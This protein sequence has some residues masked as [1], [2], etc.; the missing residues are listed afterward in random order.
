M[1]TVRPTRENIVIRHATKVAIG[2]VTFLMLLAAVIFWRQSVASEEAKGWVSHTYEVIGHIELLFGK[3]KEAVIGQRGFILTGNEEYLEPYEAVL[4]DGTN[5]DA[6]PRSLQQ[7]R[8]IAQEL[9]FIHALTPDNSAQQ[10]NLDEMNDTVKKLLAYLAATIQQRKEE[11]ANP[12]ASK[13]DLQRGKVLMDQAR[14]LVRIMEAEESHLLQLR[15][16]VA[17]TTAQQS[18]RLTIAAM[19]VFYIA[20]TLCIWLYQRS[21]AH[22][23][24]QMLNYTRELETREE[25]LKMQQE[26]L[27]A[28]NEEIEASNEELE[29][30][31]SALEEQNTRIRQQSQE[32]EETKQLI[33]EKATQLEQ[34]SKYKSEFL[35]NMSHELRTPLNSLL[36]LARCLATN[37]EGNLTEEQIEEARVIHSWRAGTAGPDQRHSRPLESR[38]GQN[39][40]RAG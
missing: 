9:A 31:T 34:S 18:N 13:V 14:A 16:D 29:E 4:K 21:R 33:E 17:E 38:G 11:G 8:S 10:S 15:S 26:E 19:I 24:A 36:I 12:G 5:L 28:S 22:A 30:K 37:E 32:L 7:R 6:G 1:D 23:Q 3:L 35:A 2:T 40:H 39:Q 27:K 20:I 25:E